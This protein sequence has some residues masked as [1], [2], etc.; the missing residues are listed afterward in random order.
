MCIRDS[1]Y[2]I[3]GVDIV[4]PPLRD[5]GSDVMLIAQ[6]FLARERARHRSG[7]QAFTSEVDS[8]LQSYGW[9]GNVRE[10]QNTIR[11]AHA[12]AGEAREID[13]EHLPERL[14]NLSLIHI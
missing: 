1:Y 3:R 13:I 8:L 12:I 14:R 7:P 10:L 5:R 11:A 2:R 6:H 9:P 4:L